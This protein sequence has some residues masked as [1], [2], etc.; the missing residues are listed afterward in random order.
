MTPSGARVG[1]RIGNPVTLRN[2]PNAVT[3]TAVSIALNNLK[4]LP[5]D[6]QPIREGEAAG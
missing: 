6:L 2:V 1:G 4:A 5:L 3:G